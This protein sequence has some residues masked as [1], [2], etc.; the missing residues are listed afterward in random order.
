MLRHARLAHARVQLDV[1]RAPAVLLLAP[2]LLV[3]PC[4]GPV[5]AVH[6]V[7]LEGPD[8]LEVVD[9]PEPTASEGSVVVD[10]ANPPERIARMVLAQLDL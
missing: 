8:A 10:V 2:A 1:A 4:G 6:V 9:A 5:R 7:R 3:V